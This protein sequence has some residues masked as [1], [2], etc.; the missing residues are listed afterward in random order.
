M[1]WQSRIV[2]TIGKILNP[3][4]GGSNEQYL[5]ST[6]RETIQSRQSVSKLNKDTDSMVAKQILCKTRVCVALSVLIRIEC[7]S[8]RQLSAARK[9]GITLDPS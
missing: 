6:P 1:P 4:E 2:H 7:Q 3:D 9:S 8:Y 5:P